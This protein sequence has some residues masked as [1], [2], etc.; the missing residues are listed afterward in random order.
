[1]LKTGLAAR[2]EDR[3]ASIAVVIEALE[4]LLDRP[5]RRRRKYVLGGLGLL[6]LAGF[7]AAGL[8]YRAAHPDCPLADE[9]AL[10]DASTDWDA[11]ATRSSVKTAERFRAR[12]AAMQTMA[13]RSCVRDDDAG[14]QHVEGLLASL[15]SLLDPADEDWAE[16]I[17]DFELDF[18][19]RATVPMSRK[20]YS[21]LNDEIRPHEATWDLPSLIAACDAITRKSWSAADRAGLLIPCARAR[22]IG[23]DY[24]AAIAD[25]KQ[26]RRAAVK[27]GDGQRQLRAVLGAAKTTIMRKQE[28]E[29]GEEL[30]DQAGDLLVALD[31]GLWDVRRADYRELEALLAA[32]EQRLGDAVALQLRVVGRQLLFGI[33][34]ERVPALVNLANHFDRGEHPRAAELAYRS[35]LRFDPRDP[36]LTYNLGRLLLNE[37]RY[38]E[39]RE[40]LDQTL[41][42]PNHDLHLTTT[43]CLLLLDIEGDDRQQ[44]SRTRDRLVEMLDD[45][46]I[47]RTP[48]QEQ[49][50]R[51]VVADANAR[52]A[53]LGPQN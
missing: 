47:P 43:T 52:L 21:A 48:Q 31:V 18:V 13:E 19:T 30:L 10:L 9:V 14:H 20:G 35:A 36:E 41:A 8:G 5:Q 2:P 15:R 4:E 39:A 23:G 53:K 29:R 38:A 24:D 37:G 51:A 33:D 26:A 44:L 22:S 7:I 3:H 46:Q 42:L 1:M 34:E 45:P 40:W 11:F 6:A 25:F 49:E 12:L 17:G 50:S 27:V 28:Y 16:H 32:H